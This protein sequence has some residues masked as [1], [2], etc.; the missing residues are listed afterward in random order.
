MCWPMNQIQNLQ[1]TTSQFF[2]TITPF[3]LTTSGIFSN[4]GVRKAVGSH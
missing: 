3:I 2:S 1:G 4:F